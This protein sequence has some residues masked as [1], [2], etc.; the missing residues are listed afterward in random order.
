M[1]TTITIET[2][3]L[4]DRSYLVHD[5]HFAVVIDPQ[6]DIDRVLE[7]AEKEQVRITHIFETHIHNDYLTGGLALAKVTGAAYHVNADDEVQFERASIR[8][9]DVIE[10]SP[11]I[12]IRAIATPGHTFTHLSY[13]L[14]TG[15]EQTGV[16]TGG[17]LLFGATGRPDLLGADH[18]D[19]LVRHQYASAHRLARELPDDA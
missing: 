11:A 18:T 5:G 10:V 13:A 2:P 8:D 16:F 19:E 6:R 17:S 15:G 3:T 4:G 7:L 9:G 14:E 12:R 1:T